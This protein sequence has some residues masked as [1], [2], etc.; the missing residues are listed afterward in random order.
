MKPIVARRQRHR[1]RTTLAASTALGMAVIIAGCGQPREESASRAEPVEL[2]Q[3]NSISGSA[4]PADP[5]TPP[6]PATPTAH[7]SAYR[8]R[9]DFGVALNADGGWAGAMNEAVRVPAD[10]PFRLR[11]EIEHPDTAGTAGPYRLEWRRNGGAWD[12]VLAENFPQPAKADELEFETP[13]DPAG[14]SWDWHQGD[15]SALRWQETSAGGHL[16]FE[17]GGDAILA[18]G[19]HD[20]HW[21]P[22]EI[23][24]RL[25]LP[26]GA[27]TAG[28]VFHYRDALNHHRVDLEAGHGLHLV[29]MQDG[30]ETRLATHRYAVQSGQWAELKVVLEDAETT[31]EYDDEALVFT[32]RPPGP[33]DALRSG[34]FVPGGSALEL[35]SVTIEGL[36]RSPRA[37]IVAGAFRHG[38]DTAD[39]LAGSDRPF[40]GGAG[41]SFARQAPARELPAQDD[42]A[43]HTEWEFPLVIRHFADGAA[44]NETG[45]R[46]E[47]RVLDADGHPV[48]AVATAAVTLEVPAGHLGGTFVE[49]P[50][51]IG[52]WETAGGDY[53]FLMEPA[54]TDNMLMAVKSSDGGASW[55]EMDGEHRPATGDLEG[56]ASVLDGDRIHMLHQTSDDVFYHVFLTADHPAQPDR[57]AVR[58]ERLA[59]PGEPPTQVADLAVRSD[60]SVVGVYGGPEKIRYRVR[61]AEGEWGPESVIDAGVGPKLSGPMLVR[62]RD[63]VIHLAYTGE[64]GTVW[65][66]QLR[67]G[68]ELTPRRLLAD[69]LGTGTEEVG[70]LVPLT[71]LPE[72]ETLSVIY[73]LADGTLWERRIGP[74][75]AFSETVQVTRRAVVQNAVDSDQVGADAVGHGDTVH[76]LFIEAGTGRLFHTS[77]TAGES[78]TEPTLQVDGAQVQWVRGAVLGR[79]REQPVYGYMYDAGSDG[80]SGMNRFGTLPLLTQAGD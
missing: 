7:Q 52:P 56:F 31:V 37:S 45:D 30:E 12:A 22:V 66:R 35:R 80:G 36:P 63:D 70:A 1:R 29:Q 27:S 8:V 68:G 76:V 33:L 79:G 77:R 42:P 20:V 55:R 14:A 49:T 23:A 19:R 6:H 71:Y 72:T 17:P 34:V 59:S 69:G 75:S 26:A 4:T 18:L 43:S 21:E 13:P 40:A 46:F 50:A 73:R 62:G 24:A 11:I 41:V 61:S 65:Y 74:D 54:E 58:D 38:T 32:E 64:D 67:P 39:L 28:L 9:S 5:G 15:E 48:P 78:W 51:R 3:A 16:R 25:R 47:F 44:R 10:Q 53:Y 60:G 2:A 57:W